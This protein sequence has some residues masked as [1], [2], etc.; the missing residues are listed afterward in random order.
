MPGG[1]G[2][3]CMSRKQ[4]IP[5]GRRTRAASGGDWLFIEHTKKNEIACHHV[6]AKIT[7][8]PGTGQDVFAAPNSPGIAL[9]TDLSCC[10]TKRY[11]SDVAGPA[12]PAGQ[13]HHNFPGIASFG[14]RFPGKS[15][16]KPL[17]ADLLQSRHGCGV[18]HSEQLRV[19]LRSNCLLLRARWAQSR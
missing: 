3:S 17:L 11:R 14:R 2:L 1:I 6:C 18:H 7:R 12:G 13:V 9:T 8:N 15:R 10:R 5:G 19:D 16:P 4:R